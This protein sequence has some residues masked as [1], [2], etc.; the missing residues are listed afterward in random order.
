MFTCLL[1]WRPTRDVL[2]ALPLW[3]ETLREKYQLNWDWLRTLRDVLM[4]PFFGNSVATRL[5]PEEVADIEHHT[6]VL[7]NYRAAHRLTVSMKGKGTDELF[8]V[9]IVNCHLDHDLPDTRVQQATEVC[10]WM[11]AQKSGYAAVVLCGDLN[12]APGEAV[13]EV[14]ESLGY[15]SAHKALKG[16]EPPVTWPTGIQAPFAE[17]GPADCLDYIYIWQADNYV[18]RAVA[19]EVWGNEP[20]PHDAT[21]YPSDH[22]ALKVTVEVQHIPSS[23]LP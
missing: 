3:V 11:E 14:F 2:V 6:L 12:A 18:C 5:S 16:H 7:G 9:W 21:L 22:A 17:G 4:A 10:R 19:A 20:A 15:I 13:H 8:K 23:G 1:S